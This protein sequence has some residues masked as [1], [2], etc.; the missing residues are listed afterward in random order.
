MWE[1]LGSPKSKKASMASRVEV[2]IFKD[3]NLGTHFAIHVNPNIAA[4]DFK[5]EIEK[6][7]LNCFPEVGEIKV[8]GLMVK[9]K[10]C[11]YHLPDSFPMKHAFQGSKG[12]WFIHVEACPRSDSDKW[13]ISKRLA[14]EIRNQT[15]NSSNVTDSLEPRNCDSANK[16]HA[17][18]K[19]KN[20]G[21]KR[22]PCLKFVPQLILGTIYL[23]K[24]KKKKKKKKKRVKKT[25]FLHRTVKGL[26]MCSH[27]GNEGSTAKEREFVPSRMEDDGRQKC[28]SGATLETHSETSLE[29]ASVSGI[30]KKYFSDYDDVTF[31]SDFKSKANQSPRE[32]Q[33]ML[34]TGDNCSQAEGSALQEFTPKTPPRILPFPLATDLSCEISRAKF[35]RTEVGKRLLLAS[36]KL[37]VSASMQRPTAGPLRFGDRKLSV[38]KSSSLVRT[39]V[40]EMSDDDE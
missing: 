24:R 10:S 7:H 2:P 35:K 33:L 1:Y 19:R 21:I 22:I 5:R 32:E 40:F 3:S 39:V 30:I 11:L 8:N 26:E 15:F 14:A 17:N 13:G 28:Q 37:G 36:N 38:S 20:R 4:G 23:S 12:T 18:C 29:T 6:A 25:Q 16:N 34:G 31:S 27:G 9:R